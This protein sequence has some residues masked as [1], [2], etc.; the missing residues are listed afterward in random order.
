ML[1][2][3]VFVLCIDSFRLG[4]DDLALSVIGEGFGGSSASRDHA[5]VLA[6]AEDQDGKADQVLPVEALP[7]HRQ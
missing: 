5:V 3:L 7:H 2:L 4:V 1:Y 6:H